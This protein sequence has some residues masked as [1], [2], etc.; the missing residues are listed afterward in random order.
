V[1]NLISFNEAVLGNLTEKQ[2]GSNYL[3]LRELR[4]MKKIFL[5][6][7]NLIQHL[8]NIITIVGGSSG[9]SMPDKEKVFDIIKKF[10]KT[11]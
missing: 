2:G 5:H 7:A 1:K 9:P 8:H 4:N 3:Q 11:L 6:G 10:S